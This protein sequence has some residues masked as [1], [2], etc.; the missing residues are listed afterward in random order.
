MVVNARGEIQVQTLLLLKLGCKPF[1][2][3]TNRT[4]TNF[5][6]ILGIYPVISLILRGG[7]TAKTD[8][9]FQGVCANLPFRRIVSVLPVPAMCDVPISPLPHH[10]SLST[11]HFAGHVFHHNEASS[12]SHCSCCNICFLTIPVLSILKFFIQNF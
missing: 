9:L 1:S 6:Y 2:S 8:E 7:N 5:S 12:L 4:V 11:F 10:P 3:V